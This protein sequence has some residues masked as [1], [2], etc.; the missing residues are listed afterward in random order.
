MVQAPATRG[1]FCDR[2]CRKTSDRR[3]MGGLMKVALSA[4]LLS[5]CSFANAQEVKTVGQDLAGEIGPIDISSGVTQ[6]QASVIAQFYSRRHIAACGAVTPPIS[7]NSD[8]EVTPLVGIEGAPDKDKIFVSKHSG[9]VSWGDGPVLDV[10]ALINSK[11]TAPE[12]IGK[13]RPKLGHPTASAVRIGFV[14]LPDGAVASTTFKQSSLNAKCD[15]RARGV[16][17]N[18]RFPPRKKAIELVATWGCDP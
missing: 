8:W 4:L 13:G 1:F 16:V 2:T 11:E 15:R 17:E 14:V 18:W 10:V 3:Y 12:P 5:I 6:R 9:R 7:R